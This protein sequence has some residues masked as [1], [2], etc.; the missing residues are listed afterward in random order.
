MIDKI[1]LKGA[2]ANKNMKQRE[3]ASLVGVSRDTIGKWEKG[4]SFPNANQIAKL[5]KALNIEY[6]DIIFLP[7][8]DA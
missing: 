5:E 1:T 6:K 2:R 7:E 3:L 4:S 8:Y